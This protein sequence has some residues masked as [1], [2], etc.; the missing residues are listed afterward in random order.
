VIDNQTKFCSGLDIHGL[1]TRNR[2]Q[3]YL[4][5]SN[6]SVFQKGT[7]LTTIKLFN[8]LP[9]PIQSLKEDKIS[10]RNKLTLYLMNNSFYT[11]SEYVEHN[12]NN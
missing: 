3:L 9:K 12:L 10:F 2:E 1:N 11:V 4:P 6:L 5:N 8:R 7:T